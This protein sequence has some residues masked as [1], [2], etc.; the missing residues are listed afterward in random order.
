MLSQSED[1]C[2]GNNSAGSSKVTCL[3]ICEHQK[4]YRV[5]AEAWTEAQFPM[6]TL[7]TTSQASTPRLF[8]LQ[9]KCHEFLK[10]DLSNRLLFGDPVRTLCVLWSVWNSCWSAVVI[11]LQSSSNHWVCSM[12]PLRGWKSRDAIYFPHILLSSD[13]TNLLPVWK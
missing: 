5:A 2:R 12:E 3:Q 1:L 9:T 13:S 10:P 4:E 11:I 7:S 8:I 6:A